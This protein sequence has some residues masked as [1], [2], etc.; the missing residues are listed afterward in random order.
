M[1]NQMK[2]LQVKFNLDNFYIDKYEV[3]NALYQSCVTAGVC[4][5]PKIPKN[6]AMYYD[7]PADINYPVVYVD[8]YMAN[9]F[10]KWRNARLPTE[11]EWEKASPSTNDYV[12]PWE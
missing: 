1:V 2:S 7:N 10:C 6:G 9:S 4:S 3:T 12:A 8:W 5:A 11:A